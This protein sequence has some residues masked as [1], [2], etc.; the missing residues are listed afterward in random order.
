[1]LF[2]KLVEKKVSL[3][4]PTNQRRQSKMSQTSEDKRRKRV[5]QIPDDLQRLVV[6]FGGLSLKGNFINMANKMQ[7]LSVDRIPTKCLNGPLDEVLTLFAGINGD[8][9]ELEKKCLILRAKLEDFND[10]CCENPKE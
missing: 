3:C 5:K 9:E 6:A 8:K 4:T 7:N 1:M 10:L 2:L